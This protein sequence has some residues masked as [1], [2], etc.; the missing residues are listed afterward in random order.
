M[1]AVEKAHIESPF[2]VDCS[3][4][5]YLLAQGEITATPH[6]WNLRQGLLTDQSVTT[7]VLQYGRLAEGECTTT[8]ATSPEP[9]M[10]KSG[11]QDCRTAPLTTTSTPLELNHLGRQRA[12]RI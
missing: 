4:R 2:V 6:L 7:V 11:K 5:F 10:L 9:P 12:L 1:R 3:G 8:A